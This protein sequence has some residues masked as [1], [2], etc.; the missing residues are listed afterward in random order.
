MVHA[1]V[2]PSTIHG[3]G[4]IA[5]EFIPCGAA[6]WEM[7]SGFD[8]EFTTKDL[9][10]FPPPVRDQILRYS[11]GDY[12]PQRDCYTLCGDDARF[13]NHS[14]N[15]NTAS[16]DDGRITMAT[17]DIQTGEEITW[18]YRSWGVTPAWLNKTTGSQTRSV[19]GM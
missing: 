14:N 6:V 4:L 17:R 9:Q 11:E 5:Q 7:R 12:D 1:R 13:T 18:D 10:S 2:G 3:L 8:L 16:V 15:P 19:K